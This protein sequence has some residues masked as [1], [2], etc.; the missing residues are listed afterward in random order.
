MEPFV[1]SDNL[2]VILIMDYIYTS[3]DSGRQLIFIVSVCL[4]TEINRPNTS[5]FTDEK[6]SL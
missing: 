3:S 5:I 4:I 6:G 2:L 1:P